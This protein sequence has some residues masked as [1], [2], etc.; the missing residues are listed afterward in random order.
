M[1]N[2][3]VAVYIRVSSEE[4]KKEGLS[5]EAQTRSL[6]EYCEFK[7]WIIFKIYKDEGVSGKSIKGRKEFIQMLE[8]SKN[9]KFSG[10]IVTKFDRAFRNVIDSLNTLDDFHERK[11]DFISISENIDT[12]TPMGKAMFTMISLFAELERSMTGKR[13]KDIMM[14]KVNRGIF[15]GKSPFGYKTVIREKR[16]VGFAIDQKEASIVQDAFKMASEG[17][18]Y[19]EICRKHGL[20]PQSYYNLIKNKVYIGIVSFEGIERKGSH[21]ALISEELFNKVNHVQKN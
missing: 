14:D 6:Q 10:I 2:K 13:N 1:E 4:Q 7:K 11:I 17:L 15:P 18:G 20:S 21:P 5:I 9:G 16:V 12:T 3:K 19:A 8:D